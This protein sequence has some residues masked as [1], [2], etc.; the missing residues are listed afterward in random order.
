MDYEWGAPLSR[1]IRSGSALRIP[2]IFVAKK[3]REQLWVPIYICDKC[4]AVW[5]GYRFSYLFVI[6]EFLSE[7]VG[8]K[9]SPRATG[10]Y[11][12][13]LRVLP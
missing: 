3:L 1:R 11:S 10:A 5:R 2:Q 4:W 8:A 12:A 7:F 9:F 6:K 13:D